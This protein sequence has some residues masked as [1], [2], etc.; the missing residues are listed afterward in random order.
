M[1]KLLVAVPLWLSFAVAA[2]A[3]M[4]KCTAPNGRTSYQE[5]PCATGA[6]GAGKVDITAQPALAPAKDNQ[7][8]SDRLKKERERMSQTVRAK[9]NAGDLIGARAVA[10]TPEDFA[11]VRAAE[12]K[13][14]AKTKHCAELSAIA[15]RAR[16]LAA[17]QP[18]SY[19]LR[20]HAD[21]EARQYK[22]ECP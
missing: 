11:L 8:Q 3:D 12:E 14:A 19:A 17:D 9:L 10:V 6:S 20:N 7:A 2:H 16:Q 1:N 22:E 13:A 21:V 18:G 15:S 4:Y 5:T